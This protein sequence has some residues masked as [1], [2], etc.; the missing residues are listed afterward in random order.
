[1]LQK[2][3]NNMCQNLAE[4]TQ[5]ETV[6][7]KSGVE[8]RFAGLSLLGLEV[9]VQAGGPVVRVE[10]NEGPDSVHPLDLSMSGK[11]IGKI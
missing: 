7:A 4:E 2:N 11:K 3:T 9:L 1:M 10:V 8:I 6:A 5:E